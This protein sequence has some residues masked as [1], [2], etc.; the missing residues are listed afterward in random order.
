VPVALRREQLLLRSATLRGQLARD[1]QVLQ[2]PLA[3]AD[4]V[5]D[6]LRWLRQNPEWPLGGVLLLLVLKPRRTWRWISRGW[7]AWRLWRRATL[8]LAP[9]R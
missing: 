6:G 9:Q 7:W 2:A 1:A 3:L 8:L 4:S 5:R